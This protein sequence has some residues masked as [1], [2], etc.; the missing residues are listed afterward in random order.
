MLLLLLLSWSTLT[1]CGRSIENVPRAGARAVMTP[2][3]IA[4]TLD[5]CILCHRRP[6]VSVGYFIP[7]NDQMYAAV[8]CLRQNPL[9]PNSTPA[10]AYGLCRKHARNIER[11]A[12]RVEA[13]I[14]AGAETTAV[15]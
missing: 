9:K 1:T 2:A 3:E 13:R 4:D 7:V 11:S 12:A 6:V 14:L 15:H 8:V 10:L 5:G